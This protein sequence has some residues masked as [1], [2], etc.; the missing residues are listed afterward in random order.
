[1]TLTLLLGL[2][3]PSLV[4]PAASSAATTTV[5][6]CVSKKNGDA[7]LFTRKPRCKRREHLLSWGIAG[8]AGSAG[9]TGPS[10]ASGSNGLNGAVAGFSASDTSE[11]AVKLEATSED[12]QATIVS[13]EV[14]AGSFLVEGS[15]DLEAVS[16]KPGALVADE[17]ELTD[18][19]AGAAATSG[20]IGF[21]ASLLDVKASLFYYA[22]GTMPV[23][24][25]F[26]SVTPSVIALRC[27]QYQFEAPEAESQFESV[28]GQASILAVQTSSNS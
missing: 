12:A 14:P 10:G 1:V 23:E 15:V 7:R 4:I 3:L 26:S 20:P 6:A 16:G 19:P 13:K 21:W 24:L 5:Y 8:P 2:L 18:T 25:A 28:A 22:A 11:T 17:C 9:P 27:Y